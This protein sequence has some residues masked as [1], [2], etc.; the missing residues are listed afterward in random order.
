[1]SGHVTR[2]CKALAVISLGLMGADLLDGD[3]STGVRIG[4]GFVLVVGLT[5]VLRP[6]VRR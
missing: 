3:V 6:S 4:I 2:F 5:E 1:M